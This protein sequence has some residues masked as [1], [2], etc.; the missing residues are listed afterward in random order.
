MKKEIITKKRK[1]IEHIRR[2]KE[3]LLFLFM[4]LSSPLVCLGLKCWMSCVC[5]NINMRKLSGNLRRR[6]IFLETGL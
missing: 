2:K 4:A 3:L 6:Q 1:A 5:T